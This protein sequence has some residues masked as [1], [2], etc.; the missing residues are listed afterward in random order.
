MARKYQI[1]K[2]PLATA[3]GEPGE[4]SFVAHG[5]TYTAKEASETVNRINTIGGWKARRLP[6]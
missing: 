4:W 5:A 6:L 1:I 2:K 3:S